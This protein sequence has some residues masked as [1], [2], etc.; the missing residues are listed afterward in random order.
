MKEKEIRPQDL[1]ARY[2]DLSA[3][4][5]ADFFIDEE[6][7]DIPC[8][9]CDS[10]DKDFFTEK[11]TFRY[12]SCSSCES[13]FVSPRPSTDSF[14]AFYKNS[15]SSAYW[16]EVFYPAVAEARRE[17]IF[18]PRVNMLTELCEKKNIK[19][20]KLIDIGA[21]YGVFLDEW[22]KKNPHSQCLAVEPSELLSDECRSKGID[23]EQCSAEEL[24]GYDNYADLVV[25]FEVLE[26]V[27]DTLAFINT[28][29]KLL[30][31]GGYLF[32]STLC[33]DGFDFKMLKEHSSQI[34]PPHHINFLSILGFENLFNRCGLIDI[35][36]TTPGKLD[37]D[38]VRNF[39]L[40]NPNLIKFDTFIDGILNDDDKA[41]A[42]QS[43]LSDNK[44][45]SHAW[46]LGKKPG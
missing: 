15:K 35:D 38:I 41:N 4:D 30:K 31:P 6:R 27:Q 21:G 18:I 10:Q 17:K 28:L 34:S 33:I 20:D 13:V 29:K 2:V 37:V 46:V 36:I 1:F 25:C 16:A 24:E 39:A 42:F 3:Q 40:N 23:V 12:V 44:L 32:I 26:H 22:V 19:I 5:A 11:H 9:A 14:D 45:S 8:I 7:V 43:F